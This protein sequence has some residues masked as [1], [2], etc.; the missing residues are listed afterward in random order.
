M[1]Y[2]ETPKVRDSENRW[3]TAILRLFF[4]YPDKEALDAS[5]RRNFFGILRNGEGQ[6]VSSLYTME[7]PTAF[8]LTGTESDV[9]IAWLGGLGVY[10]DL[11][12]TNNDPDNELRRAVAITESLIKAANREIERRKYPSESLVKAKEETEGVLAFLRGTTARSAFAQKALRERFGKKAA[13]LTKKI[14]FQSADSQRRFAL[15]TIDKMKGYPSK[16]LPDLPAEEWR[17]QHPKG[18]DH[19][20]GMGYDRGACAW[21][22][23]LGRKGHPLDPF[24]QLLADHTVAL[25]FPNWQGTQRVL[26]MKFWGGVQERGVKAIRVTGYEADRYALEWFHG[27]TSDEARDYLWHGGY[28][29]RG[30]YF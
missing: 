28:V 14:A 8:V 17:L 15:K 30:K 13:E 16:Q 11:S 20:P 26:R 23:V 4:T 7:K 10:I 29:P 19:Y 25:W 1:A 22:Y 27:M 5:V 6:R 18:N 2:D 21:V 3:P 24:D 9:L 12:Q